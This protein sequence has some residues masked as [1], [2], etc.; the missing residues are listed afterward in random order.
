MSSKLAMQESAERRGDSQIEAKN[1]DE[2]ICEDFED[3]E[4]DIDE[5]GY[6]AQRSGS[7]EEQGQHQQQILLA[8][9]LKKNIKQ[10]RQ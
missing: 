7:E 8:D 5:D 9:N 10:L 1:Q 6:L 2:I 4:E 3:E